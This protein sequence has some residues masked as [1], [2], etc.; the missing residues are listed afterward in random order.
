MRANQALMAFL[1]MCTNRHSIC[2]TVSDE[3]VIDGLVDCVPGDCVIIKP[4]AFGAPL[5]GRGA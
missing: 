4:C 5:G 3:I 1:L 2:Q